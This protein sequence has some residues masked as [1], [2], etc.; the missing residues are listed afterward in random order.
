MQAEAPVPCCT[1]GIRRRPYTSVAARPTYSPRVSCCS[2]GLSLGQGFSARAWGLAPGLCL[3]VRVLVCDK[4]HRT[5]Y[6]LFPEML[7]PCYPIIKQTFFTFPT[8]VVEFLSLEALKGA[9]ASGIYAQ[10]VSRCIKT[11]SQIPSVPS[12]APAVMAIA[13]RAATPARVWC[14]LLY[15]TKTRAGV[16]FDIFVFPLCLFVCFWLCFSAGFL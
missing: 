6:I 7:E 4:S 16:R 15:T 2:L 8:K 13:R 12:T 11:R 5:W 1:Y 14:R 10:L 3:P 9:S